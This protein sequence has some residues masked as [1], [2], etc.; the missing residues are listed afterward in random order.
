MTDD[1]DCGEDCTVEFINT[2]S[3]D[4]IIDATI[5]ERI[6]DLNNIRNAIINGDIKEMSFIING[7]DAMLDMLSELETD[8]L[9]GNTTVEWKK[10]S[11]VFSG[12]KTLE[13]GAIYV[14]RLV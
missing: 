11:K 10:T 5:A 9:A 12:R 3:T 7:A 14:T 2:E 1:I 8:I 6:A 4:S 13:H